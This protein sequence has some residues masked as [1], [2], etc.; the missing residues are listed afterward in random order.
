ME[1]GWEEHVLAG[2]DRLAEDRLGPDIEADARRYAPVGHDVIA[3][4]KH[5]RTP[6][7]QAGELRESI[8]HHME[9]HTLIVDATAPYAAAVEMGAKPHPIDTHGP[10]SLR[11]GV[12]GEYFGSHVDHPGNKPVPYLRPAL[13]RKRGE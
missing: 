13:F 11:S 4:P 5:P 7:H 3:D 2:W 12:T 10:W 8:G 1:P 6:A 9:G